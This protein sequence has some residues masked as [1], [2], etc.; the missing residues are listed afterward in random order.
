MVGFYHF[1]QVKTYTNQ[2]SFIEYQ[3]GNPIR[4]PITGI[5]QFGNGTQCTVFGFVF[6]VDDGFVG[7]GIANSTCYL[8]KLC[9]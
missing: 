2:E 5:D 9:L 6:L 7:V 1:T 8:G 4:F 3:S